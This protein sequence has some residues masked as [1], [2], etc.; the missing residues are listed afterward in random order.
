MIETVLKDK[1]DKQLTGVAT[2]LSG[3]LPHREDWVDIAKGIA[4]MAVVLGHIRFT[5]P[6]VPLLPLSTL[7]VWLWHVPVFF[8]IGG[9]FLREEKLTMPLNFTISKCKN[10]YLPLI[11]STI[12]VVLLHN[13]FIGIGFYD[14][15]VNYYG[16]FVTLWNFS[17]Y[18]KHVIQAIFLPGKE[19]LL[20]AVWFVHVLFLALIFVSVISWMLKR[21]GKNWA[22]QTFE[23][24]RCL[25]FLLL[26][27]FSCTLTQLF[28]ITVSRFNN[29]LVAVWLIYVG[30]LLVQR[31]KVKFN[32]PVLAIVASVIAWHSATCGMGGGGKYGF[33]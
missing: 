31:A 33:Q 3:L 26:A 8:M 13:V 27:V 19:P 7:F 23:S 5:W 1:E 17:E 15:K 28:N 2:T 4:I 14:I 12:P 30:M 11:L 9:F 24:V 16:Q 6:K 22:S 32:N 29:T 25:V 21:I 10:L 18:I 20:G